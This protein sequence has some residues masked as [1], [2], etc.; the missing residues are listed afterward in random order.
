M[1]SN[2]FIKMFKTVRCRR[3]LCYPTL[4]KVFAEPYTFTC[5]SG[6]WIGRRIKKLHD[7]SRYDLQKI[8]ET[9]ISS[10]LHRKY[11]TN[12]FKH[13]PGVTNERQQIAEGWPEWF[14][15]CFRG[16]YIDPR[17]RFNFPLKYWKI[18]TYLSILITFP[19]EVR[20]SWSW[21]LKHFPMC[22]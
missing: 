21:N 3:L 16:R 7:D 20:E 9:N 2:P 14:Q 18:F 4:R 22:A 19:F 1:L 10:N 8:T 5:E 17:E 15:Y 13:T 11:I 6:S 12:V